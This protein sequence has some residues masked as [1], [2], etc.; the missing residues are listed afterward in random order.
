[1]LAKG[2]KELAISREIG[3]KPV[4][5]KYHKRKIIEKLCVKSIQKAVT[6]A[7]KLNLIDID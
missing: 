4:T 7:V 5:V 2:Y 3:I 6:K 1:M